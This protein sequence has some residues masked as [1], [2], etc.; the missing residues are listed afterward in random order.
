MEH[1]SEHVQQGQATLYADI[2]TEVVDS[3]LCTD[4]LTALRALADRIC[5][6]VVIALY[7]KT[8]DYI[9]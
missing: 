7:G 9:C 2:L 8:S 6:R 3:A 4:V 1:G 5:F